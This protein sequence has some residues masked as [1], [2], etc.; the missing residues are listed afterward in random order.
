M[1]CIK[2]KP[3][4]AYII[5]QQGWRKINSVSHG[6]RGCSPVAFCFLSLSLSLTD[7][8]CW[9]GFSQ[10]C[11]RG[12]PFFRPLWAKAGEWIKRQ[13]KSIRLKSMCS[14]QLHHIHIE[15]LGL[16]TEVGKPAY[17][18]KIKVLS[19][20][21][22]TCSPVK[23]MSSA[24]GGKWNNRIWH[25]RTFSDAF[26]SPICLATVSCRF[27]GQSALSQILLL[28]FCLPTALCEFEINVLR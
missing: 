14:V 19:W 5:I 28:S 24:V 21:G 4:N 9:K 27:A 25:R 3:A 18:I 1:C 20:A 26:S 15:S 11:Q 6:S 12:E 10:A 13:K 22:S 7:W 17:K 23:V 8:L 2:L 16:G